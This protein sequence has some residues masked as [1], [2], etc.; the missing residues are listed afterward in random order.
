MLE[1]NAK[2]IR[3][4]TPDTVVNMLNKDKAAESAKPYKTGSSSRIRRWVYRETDEPW[5][6]RLDT[7]FAG[8]DTWIVIPPIR[9][10]TQSDPVVSRIPCTP[11]II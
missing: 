8:T 5:A 3:G 9:T 10:F 4:P 7:V 11:T 2:A 1:S 6:P